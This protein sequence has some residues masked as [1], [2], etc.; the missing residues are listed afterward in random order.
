VKKLEKSVISSRR[1]SI[2]ARRAQR[3]HSESV[4]FLVSARCA[5]GSAKS[6]QNLQI[7]ELT[8]ISERS[9]LSQHF[10]A[11]LE[12]IRRKRMGSGGHKESLEGTKDQ[13]PLKFE[14]VEKTREIA[15]HRVP[16]WSLENGQNP[17]TKNGRSRFISVG[18]NQSRL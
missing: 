15:K 8:A 10:V 11:S 3:K 7:S 5:L 6:A 14:E 1:K 12:K 4:E 16:K 2:S 18:L 9:A 13:A 17:L